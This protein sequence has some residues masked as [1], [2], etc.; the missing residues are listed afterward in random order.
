MLPHNTAHKCSMFAFP[1][2]QSVVVLP[3]TDCFTSVSVSKKTKILIEQAPAADV[4][5]V[6]GVHVQR[7]NQKGKHGY[8]PTVIQ[9]N[10]P[11]GTGRVVSTMTEGPVEPGR[12]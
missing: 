5:D 2:L 10:R 1:V 8:F 12:R 3:S 6:F 9:L 7:D 11:D 4:G